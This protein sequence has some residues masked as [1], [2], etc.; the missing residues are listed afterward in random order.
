MP[1]FQR[2]L[3]ATDLSA[4]ARRAA[5]RAALLC[6]ETSAAL[7]LLHVANLAPLERLRQFMAATPEAL[8][9]RVLEA[10]QH[11]LRELVDLL[12]TRFG[13]AAHTHLV[14]SV[15]TTEL[16]H[17]VRSLQADLLV[18]GA[19]GESVVRHLLMGTTALRVLSSTPCPVLVVKQAPHEPYKTV[20]VPVDFS[21]A[22]L[23]SIRLAQA[24]APG[25][26]L[27]LL[28]AFD[29][30]FEGMMEFAGVQTDQIQ[31]YRANARQEA[32]QNMEA[33]CLQAGL[34]PA[35]TPALVMHG[36]PSLVL[37]QQEQEF[38]C[39]LIVMGKQGESSVEDMLLGSVT[40]YALAQSQ[41]DVL[42]SV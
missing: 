42:I 41:C 14:T 34:N 20:L 22:S 28:H 40:R 25:A 26:A 5:E 13:V 36:D 30:P 10:A 35:L 12:Q 3:A 15:L 24:V 6:K 1:P 4:P 19:R 33:L 16:A 37:V 9:Q 38:D 31:Q 18:C 17:Q 29:V 11:K 39:D 32:R 7:D 21:A 2:I 27:I 8:R 23:R